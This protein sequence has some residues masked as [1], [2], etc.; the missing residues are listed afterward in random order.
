MGVGPWAKALYFYLFSGIFLISLFFT[1]LCCGLDFWNAAKTTIKVVGL[2]ISLIK[3]FKRIKEVLMSIKE[4][5]K[6]KTN[7]KPSF[8]WLY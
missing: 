6:N 2:L 5:F 3:L 8:S 1:L 4:R 7:V